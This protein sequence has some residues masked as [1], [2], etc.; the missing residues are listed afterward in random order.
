MSKK[1]VRLFHYINRK[2]KVYGKKYNFS[3]LAEVTALIFLGIS[4]C[5][6]ILRII[7]VIL[8]IVFAFVAFLANE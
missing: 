7:I 8:V 6:A 4:D 2:S 3:L 1:N 5:S